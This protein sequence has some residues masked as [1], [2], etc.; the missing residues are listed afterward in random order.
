MN[1]G[2][3]GNG[4][5]G[6]DRSHVGRRDKLGW[7]GVIRDYFDDKWASGAGQANWPGTTGCNSLFLNGLPQRKGRKYGAGGTTAAIGRWTGFS[8]ASKMCFVI[9]AERQFAQNVLWLQVFQRFVYATWRWLGRKLLVSE[10]LRIVSGAPSTRGGDILEA[11]CRFVRGS[12][13]VGDGRFS[14]CLRQN[15]VPFCPILCAG[16]NWT[17]SRPVTES[18]SSAASILHSQSTLPRHDS[19]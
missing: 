17:S 15:G 8:S 7:L 6:G 16:S 11:F 10:E 9:V 13:A 12:N 2:G 14:F 5:E 1:G 18:S 3:N 4:S 19:K